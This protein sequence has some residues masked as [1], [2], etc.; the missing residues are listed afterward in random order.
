[1]T[2]VRFSEPKLKLYKGDSPAR[3]NRRCTGPIN[4]LNYCCYHALSTKSTKQLPERILSEDSLA[5]RSPFVSRAIFVTLIPSLTTITPVCLLNN[6]AIQGRLLQQVKS[7]RRS[8]AP[9]FPSIFRQPGGPFPVQA[10][11]LTP[12]CQQQLSLC[13]CHCLPAQLICIN[14]T[15]SLSTVLMH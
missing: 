4:R 1:L 9:G 12:N 5:D 15:V 11:V 7:D 2:P 8:I 13:L 10:H 3:T 14:T 6:D